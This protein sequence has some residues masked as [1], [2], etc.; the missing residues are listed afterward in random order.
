MNS[1]LSIAFNKLPNILMR[2]AILGVGFHLLRLLTYCFGAMDNFDKKL[3]SES[4]NRVTKII[5]K[6]HHF[7]ANNF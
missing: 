3:F 1:E 5:I 4:L 2:K 6:F 7:L